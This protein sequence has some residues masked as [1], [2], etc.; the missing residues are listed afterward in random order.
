MQK[1][2]LVVDDRALNREFLAMLLDTAGYQVREAGNGA[3][4]LE[5]MRHQLPDLIISDI[6]MPVMDGI[7]F[8]NRL[9]AEPAHK[10]IPLIFYTATYRAIEVKK[11][12]RS[13]DVAAIL[14]KP[15][16]PETILTAVASALGFSVP[17]YAASGPNAE[18]PATAFP[19]LAGLQYRL[20]T[21]ARAPTEAGDKSG[22]KYAAGNIQTLSLRTAALLELS[23]TLQLEREPQQL[24]DLFCRAAQDIMSA[25]YAALG[26][27]E[28]GKIARVAQCGMSGSEV[29]AIYA[30]LNP[31]TGPLHDILFDGKLL[32]TQDRSY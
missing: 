14:A 12:A 3:D 7:E 10:H 32:R 23:M 2:I 19:E 15:A 26:M 1:T 13:C 6:L 18:Y 21:T 28:A 9:R 20:R 16:E 31:R 25:K 4:A 27:N 8:A 5:M 24:L 22:N 17:D 29:E 11:L 30:T